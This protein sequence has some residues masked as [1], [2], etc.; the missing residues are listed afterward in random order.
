MPDTMSS[1][2]TRMLYAFFHRMRSLLISVCEDKRKEKIRTNQKWQR[3]LRCVRAHNNQ[4]SRTWT[5]VWE[6][7][8]TAALTRWHPGTFTMSFGESATD[9]S[10]HTIYCEFDSRIWCEMGT[11]A[12]VRVHVNGSQT[13]SSTNPFVSQQ[14]KNKYVNVNEQ[15]HNFGGIVQPIAVSPFINFLFK[16]HHNRRVCVRRPAKINHVRKCTISRNRTTK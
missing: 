8:G 9:S 12:A 14:Q 4:L 11:V 2:L 15:L 7:I 6:V 10:A 5:D 16:P 1:R 3:T 13:G